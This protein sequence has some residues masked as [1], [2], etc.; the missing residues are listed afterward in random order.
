MRRHVDLPRLDALTRQWRKCPPPAV[1]LS[2]IAAFL[3]LKPEQEES[4]A[5][6]AQSEQAAELTKLFPVGP[7]PKILSPQEYL[8]QKNQLN[9]EE[10]HG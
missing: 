9:Q 5:P 3:G 1:Q 10:N 6:K 2:R 7:M 4:A 8:Q